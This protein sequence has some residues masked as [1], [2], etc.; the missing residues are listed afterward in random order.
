MTRKIDTKRV[1]KLIK[2]MVLLISSL[3]IIY[4]SYFA[5]T[6]DNREKIADDLK[7]KCVIEY[8][9]NIYKSLVC[10]SYWKNFI[11]ENKGMKRSFWIGICLPILLF[12]S[13]VLINFIDPKQKSTNSK[14]LVNKTIDE[15]IIT[16]PTQTKKVLAILSLVCS[17]LGGYQLRLFSLMAI[18]L[19]HITLI[20]I[21]KQPDKFGGKGFAIAGLIFGYLGLILM[22]I[23]TVLKYI[24]LKRIDGLQF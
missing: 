8:E 1:Y 13:K 22:I 17:I 24:L 7:E 6:I 15:E 16:K 19:G 21:K 3:S 18:I 14:L 2:F 10:D 12:G 4:G 9:D 23:N 11:E 5:F 20:K